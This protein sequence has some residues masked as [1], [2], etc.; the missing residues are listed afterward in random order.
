[1]LQLKI[2]DASAKTWL[3]QT[4]E[5]T[6]FFFLNLLFTSHQVYGILLTA[7]CADGHSLYYLPVYIQVRSPAWHSWSSMQG[8]TKLQSRCKKAEPSLCQ[9]GSGGGASPETWG[10]PPSSLSAGG[11]QFLVGVGLRPLAP[12]GC[13]FSLL[14]TWP[15]AS[16][17]LVA[18]QFSAASNF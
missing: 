3:R 4:N 11:T 16:A 13:L 9:Q 5:K 18:L 17:R 12:M 14:T 15:Q 2:S 7:A 10:P 1:M 6:K 8:P